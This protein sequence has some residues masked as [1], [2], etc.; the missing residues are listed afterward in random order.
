MEV[1]GGMA[2]ERRA[3]TSCRIPATGYLPV[4]GCKEVKHSELIPSRHWSG[5]NATAP[6]SK[7]LIKPHV[8]Q[9]FL[10]ARRTLGRL[11]DSTSWRQACSKAAGRNF[12][13]GKR[14][15][16]MKAFML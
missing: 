7:A 12:L 5:T 13:H 10:Q 8:L 14:T 2:R 4:P 3:D 9:S 16:R 15:S 1:D 11:P 6:L